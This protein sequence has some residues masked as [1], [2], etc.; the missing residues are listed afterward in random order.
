MSKFE[1]PKIEV[2]IFSEPMVVGTEWTSATGN[3]DLDSQS[4]DNG[5]MIEF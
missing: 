2:M 1:T 3:G 4:L 5:R